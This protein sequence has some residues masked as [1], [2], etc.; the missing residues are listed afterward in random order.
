MNAPRRK[1][2]QARRADLIDAAFQLFSEK[3][4]AETTV[5]DIVG[6][7][8]VAQGTFYL[9]FQSKNDVVNAVV[10]RITDGAVES[11]RQALCDEGLPVVERLLATS[12]A[13]A[14]MMDEPH[15]IELMRLYHRPENVAVHDRATRSINTRVAPLISDVLAQGIAAGTFR[16]DLDPV[17]TAS[18]ILGGLQAL[19]SSFF[20]DGRTG[21]ATDD[22][23]AFILRG[24]GVTEG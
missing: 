4:V 17:A 16:S 21:E 20:D 2:P 18:F 19:E 13:L 24:L 12:S 23:R 22:L 5:S 3:G 14:E 9:Y 8:G 7:A 1:D 10:E 15:E 6:A 11:M